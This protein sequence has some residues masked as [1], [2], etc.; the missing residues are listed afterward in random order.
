M[1]QLITVNRAKQ[2]PGL[3]D[4]NSTYLGNL[5]SAASNMV[6]NHCRR[7]FTAANY[8]NE[9]HDGTGMQFFY[10]K[11]YPVTTLTSITITDS[12][13]SSETIAGT[14]FDFN[15]DN[16]KVQFK[17]GI[18]AAYGYFPFGTQNI[19][20]TYT[21]GYSTIPDAVQ[22][23]VAQVVMGLYAPG[24]ASNLGLQ[25]ERLGEYS[26]ARATGA[27]QVVVTPIVEALLEPYVKFWVNA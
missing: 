15:A 7:I 21:A 25:S 22:E 1:T 2:V 4:V 18:N 20:V 3:A 6:E 12:A 8:T 27:A 17:T 26:F 19:A 14:S 9:L 5:I 13:N 24:A 10:L 16:G 23:A 11:A